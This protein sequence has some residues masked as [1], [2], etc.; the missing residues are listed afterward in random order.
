M[1]SS[2]LYALPF[3]LAAA[4]VRGHEGFEYHADPTFPL[5][6]SPTV[7]DMDFDYGFD[8]K[9][10]DGKVIDF[11]SF[12][13]KVVF[14]NVWATWCGPCRFELPSIQKLYEGYGDKVDFVMLSIDADHAT[15][16]VKQFLQAYDYSFP[17]F[18]PKGDLTE[19]LEVPVIP[20]TFIVDKNGKIAFLE[21][22]V[23]N[24][25][26]RKMRQFI[27]ELVAQESASTR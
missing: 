26:S 16:K 25:N 24:Y 11:D 1:K 5:Q 23:K 21:T 9:T 3:A 13:N 14:I 19:Q 2:L 17:V 15:T 18:M 4:F 7:V 6:A 12:R 8:V 20:T 10:L 27:D 22:G